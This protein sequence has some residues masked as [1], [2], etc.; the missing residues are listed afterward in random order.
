MVGSDM[1]RR[2]GTK[3]SDFG[4]S[5]RSGHDSTKFYSGKVYEKSPK[6]R[7]KEYIE[8]PLPD[9]VVN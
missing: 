6:E 8:N 7:H 3:T 2:K 9:E 4:S 1:P 5:G